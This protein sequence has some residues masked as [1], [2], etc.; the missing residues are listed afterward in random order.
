M[1]SFFCLDAKERTK[2]KIKAAEQIQAKTTA[3][4][5]AKMNSPRL[6]RGSNSIFADAQLALFCAEFL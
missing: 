1:C 4:F 3:R 5:A 6:R 2:E